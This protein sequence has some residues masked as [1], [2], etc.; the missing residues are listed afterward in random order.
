MTPELAVVLVG[1]LIGV[2]ILRE[3]VTRSLRACVL[4][5]VSTLLALVVVSLPAP[6][7]PIWAGSLLVLPFV[8]GRLAERSLS[9]LPKEDWEYHHFV[10]MIRRDLHR[11]GG[12][13]PRRLAASE[14]ALRET[15][16]PSAEWGKVHEEL[17]RQLALVR[18]HLGG[19]SRVNQSN[20]LTSRRALI[21]AWR[22]AIQSRRR[23][24]R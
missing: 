22:H 9:S 23:F 14:R 21:S 8:I 10:R 17:V 11:S 6:L 1:G 20:I 16:P 15:P 4:V 2:V 24:I 19:E 18:Q 7:A 5:E 3:P 13:L 12:D